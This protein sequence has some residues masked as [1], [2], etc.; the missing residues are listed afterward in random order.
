MSN[1]CEDDKGVAP[2]HVVVV[3]VEEPVAIPAHTAED[4]QGQEQENS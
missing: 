1:A 3:G 4:A 2:G